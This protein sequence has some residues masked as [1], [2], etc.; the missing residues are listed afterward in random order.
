MT[1]Y[2]EGQNRG[3]YLVSK[4]NGSISLEVG[5]V[6]A[7]QNLAAGTVVGIASDGTLKALLRRALA[8]TASK[9]SG[10]GNGALGTVT[11]GPD[12]LVGDYILTCTE[13]DADAGTFSVV[14]PGGA[15]LAPLTVGEAYVSTHISFTVADG[16]TDWGAGAVLKVAVAEAAGALANEQIAVGILDDNIDATL[17]A[18]KAVYLARLGEVNGYELVWPRLMTA[19]NKAEAMTA[20][21]ARFIVAR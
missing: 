14:A 9:V 15:V 3:E 8:G 10:T 18:K 20:L 16:S 17:G 19:T 4:G 6:A 12:A 11:L 13:E 7:G 1:V 5:T 2:N 21:A